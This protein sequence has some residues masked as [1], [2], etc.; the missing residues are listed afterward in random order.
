MNKLI[1]LIRLLLI[2][3]EELYVT[4]NINNKITLL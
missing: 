1:F 2:K 3:E 4:H